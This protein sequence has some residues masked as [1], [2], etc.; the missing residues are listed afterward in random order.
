MPWHHCKAKNWS[1]KRA[2]ATNKKPTTSTAPTDLDNHDDRLLATVRWATV[3]QDDLPKSVLL[4]D[5]IDYDDISLARVANND[6]D[7]LAAA[8][9]G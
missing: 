2:R 4:A 8:V 3:A 6:L 9:N 5:S 1:K 7:T